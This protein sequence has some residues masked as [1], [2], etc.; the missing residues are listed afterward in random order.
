MIN[1]DKSSEEKI[2]VII[3]SHNSAGIIESCLEKLVHPQIDIW[4]ADNA[5]TDA[6]CEIITKKFP[7]TK[8]LKLEK[9]I[10]YGP[11]TNAAL[12]QTKTKYAL[13]IN[14]D[15]AIAA[16]NIVKLAKQ[17]S[18]HTNLA[19]SSVLIKTYVDGKLVTD[20]VTAIDE[21]KQTNFVDRVLGAFML[22]DMDLLRNKIGF[23]D[24][25]IFMYYEDD[26]L[27]LRTRRLG[28]KMAIFTNIEAIHLGG[29]SS[30]SN[31]YY[32]KIKAWHIT[33]AKLYF[34]KLDRGFA[35]CLKLN[36]SFILRFSFK[37]LIALLTLKTEKLEL[38]KTR[39][40]AAV[41]YLFGQKAFDKHGKAKMI[42]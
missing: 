36:I 13:L 21:T 10:G 14:P 2:S 38:E 28:Y 15:I 8:L 22:F 33:W 5:S 3:V 35:S 20:Y 16:D 1:L 9:N 37:S 32:K 4:V 40:C 11:A 26:E 19:I 17:H 29:K 7:D 30:P 39:L 23:F 41:C 24:E 42:S 6:T 31:I 27:C 12:K 34:R 25:N 18:E